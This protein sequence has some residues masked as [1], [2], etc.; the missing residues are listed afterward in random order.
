MLRF[1][2]CLQLGL[3]LACCCGA[4]V[5]SEYHGQVVFGDSGVPGATVTATRGAVKVSVVSDPLGMY[6]FADLPDGAWTIEVEMLCFAPLKQEVAISA[7]TAAGRWELKL[8]PMAEIVAKANAP[9]PVAPALVARTDAP[10]KKDDALPDMPKP[11][12]ESAPR[13]ADGLLIQGSSNNAATSQYTLAAAF[14]NNRSSKS[15]YTGG[16]SLV[17]DN[18]AFDARPYSL[19]G[20]N[21]PKDTY[22]HIT[23]GLTFGGPLNIPH[24]MRHGPNFFAT[25]QW[26]RD[27]N[28]ATQSGLVPTVDQRGGSYAGAVLPIDPVAQSLLS[29]YPLPNLNAGGRYNYQTQVIGNTHQDAVS[30]RLDRNIGRKDSVFG[31]FA[32][33]STRS[34]AANLFGFVDTTDLLG[35]NTSASWSHRYRQFYNTAS[36]RFSRLRTHVTPQFESRLNVS[37][38]AGIS[39]DPAPAGNDQSPA[40]WGPPTLVFASGIASLGDAQSSLNRNETNAVSDSVTWTHRRHNFTVGGD[41]RRQET[42]IFSQENPRGTYTFTGAYAQGKVS[43]ATA[44]GADFAD[45]LLGVPD[46]SAIAFGNA[47]KYLRQTVYDVYVN[48]DWRLRPELT[49]N[50]GLRYDYGAPVT[51][52]KGRLVNLD[53]SPGF[54]AVAPVLGSA[55]TGSLTQQHYPASLVRPD[56]L[57]LEPRVAVS[58]R[59]IPAST[60]VLRA[61]YGIYDDTSVYQTQAAMLAQQA[62][63]SKSLSESYDA[64]TCPLSLENGFPQCATTT[65]NTFAVDPNFRVGYAQTWN[66]SAQRDLPG[67][68]VGTV[69]YLGIK[70]TRG[71]QEYLPNSYPLGGA[72]PCPTCPSGFVY[73]ASNG[74]STRESAQL[75]LRRRLRSGFA[76]SLQ[77]TYSKS[78]DNDSTLGGQGPVAAGAAV[79]A[80]PPAVVAQDWRNLNAERGLS[81]FDQRHLLNVQL[82]FTSG[83]GKG[84]G[85]LMS[86]WRGTLLKEWTVLSQINTGTGLPETPIYLAATPGTGFTGSIRPNRTGASLYAAPAGYHLNAAAYTAPTPGQ[87][88]N[89]GRDSITGPGQFTLIASLQR[90]FRMRNHLNMDL[91]VDST[92]LLNHVVFT[93]WNTIVNGTTFGLP[94][95]ANAMRSLQTTVRV[96]Y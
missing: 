36:Y 73:R 76:A 45:F 19:T 90:T 21:T 2:R 15:L 89:A 48:D 5:A 33:Q 59:P 13:P 53:V 51:E 72:N 95:S 46:T 67:A 41:L 14:G 84:G 81:T 50:L 28:A 78:I 70:G 54:T 4:A 26:T 11:A 22:N 3:L 16:V 75:Q 10:K 42:N 68:L 80:L 74:N 66:V 55:P 92:N 44:A 23:G 31:V 58:W 61:G 17:L 34:D 25:Y 82:Q 86:G 29:F 87:W 57:G 88:G 39:A 60:L 79:Q 71:I 91:R 7:A 52:T 83:M 62:P 63:L 56:R 64:A 24:L 69:S 49:L 27:R 12:D 85:T 65:A 20:L 8:L 38:K 32:L 96:R 30:T 40:S 37:G 35:I 77:Y 47:D 9:R 43:G 93:S 18:S 94:A 6:S 1:W